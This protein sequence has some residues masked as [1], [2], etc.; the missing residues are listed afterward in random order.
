MLG[1]VRMRFSGCGSLKTGVVA[2]I[3]AQLY[4]QPYHTKIPRS[5]PVKLNTG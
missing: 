3:C 5:A 4:L 1:V 2:K